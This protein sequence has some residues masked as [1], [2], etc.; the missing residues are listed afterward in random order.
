VIKERWEK[1]LLT[2]MG[3][4]QLGDPT[5]A[6]RDVPVVDEVCPRC[7]KLRSEHEVIR[8]PGLTYTRC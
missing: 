7:G 4:P 5:R 6:T 1:F 2:F 3:P 8:E